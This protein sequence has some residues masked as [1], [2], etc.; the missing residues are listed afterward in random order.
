M[1]LWPFLVLMKNNMAMNRVSL[2]VKK[3]L[4]STSL[5]ASAISALELKMR[6]HFLKL[7]SSKNLKFLDLLLRV[8]SI[9]GNS[10]ALRA[11]R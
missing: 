6:T 2:K 8:E 5:V 4:K 9:L 1:L 10:V 7:Q 3:M 11:I